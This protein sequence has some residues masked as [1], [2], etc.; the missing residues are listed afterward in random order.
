M[1]G[2]CSTYGGEESCMQ[3]FGGGNLREQYHLED[4]G[5]DGRIILRWIVRKWDVMVWTGSSWLRV[6]TG[7]GHL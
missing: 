5:V 2:E 1:D 3:G 7:G 6:G 4:A